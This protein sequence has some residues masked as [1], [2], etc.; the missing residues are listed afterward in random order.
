MGKETPLTKVQEAHE[1]RRR[2]RAK[3]AHKILPSFKVYI[4]IKLQANL[5]RG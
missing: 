5:T 2:V 4:E 3:Y 1:I